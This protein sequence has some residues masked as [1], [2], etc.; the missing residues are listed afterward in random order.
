MKRETEWGLPI[1]EVY[2]PDDIEDVDYHRDLND[3]GEYPF[4][5]G[6]HKGGYRTKD[7]SRR[8]TLG[9]GFPKDTN[10][11][12][13]Y[14]LERGQKGGVCIVEDRTG[15]MTL[16]ADHPLGRTEAGIVGVSLSSRVDMEELLDGVPL[17]GFTLSMQTAPM[18]SPIILSQLIVLAEERGVDPR[19]LRGSV[20]AAPF[21]C[22][23]GQED[24]QPFDLSWK[25]FI[26]MLEYMVRNK[27]NFHFTPTQD[28]HLQESGITIPYQL[29]I[30][31]ASIRELCDAMSARGLGVDEF[32]HRLYTTVSVGMRFL[33]EVAKIRALRK[34]WAKMA[35][36][37]Y[38]A[39][40]PRTC[41]INLPIKASGASLTYQQP[42]NNIIRG[43]VECVA[44][45]IA[46]GT[47]MELSAFDEPHS[48]PTRLSSRIALATTNIVAYETGAADTA[49]PLGGSYY[50]EYLTKTIEQEAWKVFEEIE[51]IG[52][53]A[54]A[55]K[56]GWYDRLW[57]KMVYE[58]QKAIEN[59]DRI[60]VGVNELA[61]PPEEEEQ[62][63][64]HEVPQEVSE[65]IAERTTE[66]KKSRDMQKVESALANLYR[67]AKRADVNIM[68]SIIKAVRAYAT[69]QEV[70]GVI[71]LGY[72]LSYDPFDMVES[73]FQF[74]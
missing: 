17:E 38:N 32:G 18:G 25:V 35:R 33:E 49:D 56:D 58:K 13:R 16:D 23:F 74:E 40:N 27:M 14:L 28:H 34:M 57:N 26:D 70:W 41:H 66:F 65:A 21:T 7:Y 44:G 48:E 12:L 64:I 8:M 54:Q 10:E 72:G 43:A 37:R 30:V 47:A 55:I 62:I 61:I 53:L 3:P 5:R 60:V 42:Y 50:V 46:G 6:T 31:M 63:E 71:R 29:G 68:P 1:K 11:R 36:E 4:T 73:P 19:K 22:V 24:P 51:N 39:Q 9:F 69:R 45:I 20:G 52:G 2:N 15:D 67:D 59:K